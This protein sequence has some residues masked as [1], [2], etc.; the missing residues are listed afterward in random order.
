M[1]AARVTDDVPCTAAAL[2][3]RVVPGA[4]YSTRYRDNGRP[5]WSECG[6]GLP[7]PLGRAPRFTAPG[8]AM[9]QSRVSQEGPPPAS[10]PR[11]IHLFPG[12]GDF[13]LSPLLRARGRLRGITREVF[14]EVDLVSARHGLPLLAPWLLGSAP[15]SGRELARAPAGV[16]QL[17]LFGASL[18]VHR[19]LRESLGPPDAMVGVSFGEIAALTAAGA[20]DLT[21]GAEIAWELGRILTSTCPGGLTLLGCGESAAHDLLS[22]PAARDI[23]VACVNDEQET[24]VSG[25]VGQLRLMEK[26]AAEREIPAVRLRLPFSS[27]HPALRR[28]AGEFARVVRRHPV[29]PTNCVV[30]S[31]VAR[32]RYAPGEDVPARLADCLVLPAHVPDAITLAAGHTLPGQTVRLFEAGTGSALSRNARR[33]LAGRPATVHA[34]LADPDFS[35]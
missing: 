7:D 32:R 5:G 14:E 27:H 12:Q 19:A 3:A 31:A 35:W 11:D 2:L 4:A 33:I 15:P 29:R 10:L 22:H 1:E 34:P 16:A 17:A 8:K 20:F 23:A 30:L 13:P 28:Q 9:K 24:V 21:G 18:A 6:T 25:P 26:A